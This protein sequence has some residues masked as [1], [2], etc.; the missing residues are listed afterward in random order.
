MAH[1]GRCTLH[2]PGTHEAKMCGWR[3]ET[4]AQCEAAKLWIDMIQTINSFD[5]TD[6]WCVCVCVCLCV[7]GEFLDMCYRSPR[8]CFH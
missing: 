5:I 4:F 8:F 1:Q 3:K 2:R 6:Y 7:L